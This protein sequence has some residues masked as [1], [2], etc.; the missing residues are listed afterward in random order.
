MRKNIAIVIPGSVAAVRAPALARGL[1]SQR[2]KVHVVVTQ[3]LMHWGETETDSPGRWG[4]TFVNEMKRAANGIVLVNSQTP[5]TQQHILE[6]A[7]KIIVFPATANIISEIAFS[8]PSD[9]PSL[10]KSLAGAKKRLVV[11]P[12]MNARM[13]AHPA[14]QRNCLKLFGQGVVILGPDKNKSASETDFERSYPGYGRVLDTKY[15]VP[16]LKE[17]LKGNDERVHDDFKL[18][19]RTALARWGALQTEP[20]SIA[21]KSVVAIISGDSANWQQIHDFHES[22]AAAGASLSYV[23]DGK[24]NIHADALKKLAG[25]ENVFSG[26]STAREHIKLSRDA[27]CVVYPF[28]TASQVERMLQGSGRTLGQ[29]LY[30][31]ALV[32]ENARVILCPHEDSPLASDRLEALSSDDVMVLPE[33]GD[34]VDL[35]R[36]IA[37]APGL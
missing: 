15:I 23:L 3:T 26:M 28:P 8:S 6:N 31:A 19:R 36:I 17:L 12:A 18:A 21:N 5:Q 4:Q 16:L 20:P 33:A 1:S 14:V 7:A 22:I 2:Q 30:L 11:V 10:A 32:K 27:G 24:A 13:W 35:R 34:F 29:S 37:T 25:D 9:K